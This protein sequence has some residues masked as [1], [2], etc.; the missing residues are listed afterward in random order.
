MITL[1][2]I[3]ILKRFYP[4]TLNSLL[5]SRYFVF[6]TQPLGLVP[7]KADQRMGSATLKVQV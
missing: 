3:L 4:E 2:C 7:A 1:I 5:G 6:F